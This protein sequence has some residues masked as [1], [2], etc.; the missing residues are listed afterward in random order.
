MQITFILDSRHTDPF[1]P[2]PT[3]NPDTSKLGALKQRSL[4]KPGAQQL[5]Q[6]VRVGQG[7]KPT[8][9]ATPGSLFSAALSVM[10]GQ[11][12]NSSDPCCSSSQCSKGYSKTRA[13]A[14]GARLSSRS[15]EEGVVLQPGPTL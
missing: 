15:A 11:S 3:P 5:R 8:H 4:G 9:A 14:D 12:W 2:F 13:I 1:P 6:H 10:L 7:Q